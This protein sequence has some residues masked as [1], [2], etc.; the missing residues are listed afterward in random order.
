[1]ERKR[2]YYVWV[3]ED[4][5]VRMTMKK[6]GKDCIFS[7]GTFDW[8]QALEIARVL[9]EGRPQPHLKITL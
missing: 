7:Y 2:M 8:N 4:D 5:A 1:M 6:P 3:D 9:Y